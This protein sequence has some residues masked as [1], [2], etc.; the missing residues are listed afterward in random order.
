VITFELVGKTDRRV[1]TLK[2]AYNMIVT[3]GGI[4]NTKTTGPTH[5][6]HRPKTTGPAH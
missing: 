2:P 1:L 4:E 3:C 5:Q 6:D